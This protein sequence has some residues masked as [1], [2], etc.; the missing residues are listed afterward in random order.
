MGNPLS[1]PRNPDPE[2]NLE[3]VRVQQQPPVLPVQQPQP[4]P[5]AEEPEIVP[6]ELVEAQLDP[7]NLGKAP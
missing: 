1:T 3:V 2:P 6:E 4:Q 5:G 7:L